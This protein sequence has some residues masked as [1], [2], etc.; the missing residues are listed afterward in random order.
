MKYIIIALLFISACSHTSLKTGELSTSPQE[1]KQRNMLLGKWKGEAKIANG[2]TY[3]WMILRKS[4]G[5]YSHWA[6]LDNGTVLT[7]EGTWGSSG[8]IYFRTVKFITENDKKT[9]VEAN[10]TNDAAAEII[11]LKESKFTFR[12]LESGEEL[13]V[14]KINETESEF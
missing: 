5:T 8:N 4:D 6:K 3:K 12:Y 7:E 9:A 10:A 11:S 14:F 2:K 1:D 13:T